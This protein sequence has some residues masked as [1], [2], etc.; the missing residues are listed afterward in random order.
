M[1]VKLLETEK[2]DVRKERDAIKDQLC[3]LTAEWDMKAKQL[4]VKHKKLEEEMID[5][6]ALR[7]AAIQQQASSNIK[8]KQLERENNV[9]RRERDIVKEQLS[10]LIAAYDN[11]KVK[12][13]RQLTK[14]VTRKL[15]KQ[16]ADHTIQVSQHVTQRDHV[17]GEM[18]NQEKHYMKVLLLM[19]ALVSLLALYI[20][21]YWAYYNEHY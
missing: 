18:T 20:Y 9:I 5:T 17:T 6:K 13:R 15:N 12:Q 1:K 16:I 4:Q 14:S 10:K 21:F 2:D 11:S 8:V 7:D 3:K 19:F